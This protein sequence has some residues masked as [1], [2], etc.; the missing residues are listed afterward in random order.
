M[1]RILPDLLTNIYWTLVPR[2]TAFEC[3]PRRCS[4]LWLSSAGVGP[5]LTAWS[6]VLGELGCWQARGWRRVRTH[7]FHPGRRRA[8]GARF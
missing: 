7:R 4:S 6:L 5:L 1:P 2:R 8:V 3:R